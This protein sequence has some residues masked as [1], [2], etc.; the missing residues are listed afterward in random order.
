MLC[1][2]FQKVRTM[3]EL[4]DPLMRLFLQL[5]LREVRANSRTQAR[6]F[7]DE[8]CLVSNGMVLRME[9]KQSFL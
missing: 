1:L 8:G 6:W 7:S 5:K 2:E 4:G 9:E 3:R